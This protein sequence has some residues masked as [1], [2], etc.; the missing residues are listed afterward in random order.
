MAWDPWPPPASTGGL[1]LRCATLLG[2]WDLSSLTSC[3]KSA[4]PSPTIK[5]HS[6]SVIIYV[7]AIRKHLKIKCAFMNHDNS[8][9][10]ISAELNFE[11][12]VI[13]N[14]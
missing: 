10:Q 13:S 4:T 1:D 8:L 6:L 9:P 7:V 14:R 12:K 3:S 11:C 5:R 2:V